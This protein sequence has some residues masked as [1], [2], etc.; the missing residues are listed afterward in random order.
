MT[1]KEYLN[2]SI[3]EKIVKRVKNGFFDG[4][5]GYLKAMDY[6]AKGLI[7]LDTVKA[8]DDEIKAW[9][10]AQKI[11]EPPVEEEVVE[12]I[13]NEEEPS[14]DE[15]VEGVEETETTESTEPVEPA[16]PTEA[17][18][19]VEPTEATELTE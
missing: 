15:V 13:P 11:P 16:E 5:G 14:V 12:E 6:Y 3:R 7:T 10:E 9:E 19:Q 2:S 18:E 17:T 1:D 8:I 4:A